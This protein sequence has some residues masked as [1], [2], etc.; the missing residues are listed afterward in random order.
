MP[1]DFNLLPHEGIQHLKP[2]IPGKSIAEVANEHGLQHIIKLASNE[3]PLGCSPR[4]L[5]ALR[6]LTP[7]EI[8]T[9]PLATI[10]PLR[11]RLAEQLGV[12]ANMLTFGN[13][14]DGLFPLFMICF[15]LHRNKHVIIPE[16]SFVAYNVHAHGLG[17][18]VI[19]TPI[20]ADWA[21]DVDA[22]I[23][24]VNEHTALIYLANPNN[25]TGSITP[26]EEIQRILNNIP[27]ST[28]LV[29]DEAYY[30]Y[31][32]SERQQT[33]L[34]LMKKHQ[35]L[36]I[37]RT[38]SKI[39]GIASLRLGYCIAHPDMTT[40]FHKVLPPFTV[41]QAS[42][43]AACAALDDT[44]FIKQSITNNIQGMLQMQ[45]GLKE[46]QLDY[47]PPAGNFIT[48]DFKQDARDLYEQL[49]RLGIIVR[50]LHSYNMAN[51]L[52]VTIGTPPQIHE[53][54]DKLQI[55]LEAH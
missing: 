26:Y 29:V 30:E 28:I 6:E 8:A 15:A 33:A 11:Q 1:C 55:C 13:G 51:Y 45:I 9:Y 34:T 39:Y 43:V 4:V 25:P 36:I 27:E 38:F 32:D 5:N 50:P 53:F 2:Y 41:N 49:Q 42:L 31:L 52:R 48:V 40:I 20:R 17:L 19:S 46:L 10:H 18:P 21:V 35:N 3:N 14:T 37:T 12:E 44:D 47:L 7:Q 16:Y 24:A 22:L 23:A 54:L